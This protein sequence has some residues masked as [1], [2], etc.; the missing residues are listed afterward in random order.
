MPEMSLAALR[1][2]M[3]DYRGIVEDRRDTPDMSP[4]WRNVP[5]SLAALST[6]F[7]NYL[8]GTPQIPEAP[9]TPLSNALG[10]RDIKL[11]PQIPSRS[12]L[13]QAIDSVTDSISMFRRPGEK[14][15]S[16]IPF[17]QRVFSQGM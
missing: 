6:Q 4:E 14:L 8:W 16:D 17:T 10:K 12:P 11:I 13:D 9:D 3:P 1:R 2:L 7:G 15:G 5:G